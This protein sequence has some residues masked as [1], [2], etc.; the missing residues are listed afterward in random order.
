MRYTARQRL[1]ALCYRLTGSAA[2]ADDLVHDSFVRA[3]ERPPPDQSGGL[4]RWLV[5]VATNLSLDELRRRKRQA[6]SG[7]WLPAP[8]DIEAR[9]GLAV[10]TDESAEAGPE[11]RYGLLESRSFAFLIAMEALDPRQRAVLILRDALDYSAREARRG[12]VREQR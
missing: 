8:V 12:R 10:D 7:E 9:L 1:W 5:R 6:Y 2:G 3:M 11:A 4:E